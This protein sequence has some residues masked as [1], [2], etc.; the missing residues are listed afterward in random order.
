MNQ[1]LAT[2]HRLGDDLLGNRV[3]DTPA[4]TMTQRG[5]SA[6][7]EIDYVWNRCLRG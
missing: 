3:A 7:G 6:D 5:L 2:R 4:D 1:R